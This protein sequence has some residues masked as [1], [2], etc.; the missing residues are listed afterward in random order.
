MSIP[1][2]PGIPDNPMAFK[3]KK[4]KPKKPVEKE[5]SF[6]DH[7]EELR[8]HIIRAL[9]ALVTAAVLVYILGD[10][11]FDSIIFAP[12]YPDFL[13]YRAMCGLSQ[14]LGL[15][16]RLCMSPVDFEL[17]TV[18]MGEAFLT[19][20]KVALLGGLV[21]AF[22]FVF[23]EFWKFIKPGLHK[24]EVKTTRGIVFVCSLLFTFGVAFG[25]FIISPFAVNFLAGYEIS[26]VKNTVTISSM[27]NYMI[28]FTVPTGLAFELPLVVYYLSKLGLVTPEGMRSYRKHAFVTILVVAAVITPPDVITQ[29]LIGVPLYIL[30]EL[31]IYISAREARRFE[32]EFGD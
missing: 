5:M 30:Y 20:I 19:H 15:G 8:M 4:K 25:Y 6:L 10:R 26:G 3:R 12:K 28:M 29:F 14:A 18:G 27:V 13:S 31:S 2:L 1:C 17:M 11:F 32:A 24:K 16:E 21:V 23:W 7:L 22:P 9:I